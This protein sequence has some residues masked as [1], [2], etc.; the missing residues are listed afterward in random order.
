MKKPK[1]TQQQMTDISVATLLGLERE[2]ELNAKYASPQLQAKLDAIET[3]DACALLVQLG[4]PHVQPQSAQAVRIVKR[5]LKKH[6][7]D[8]WRAAGGPSGAPEPEPAAKTR[9]ARA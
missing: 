5:W 7:S 1:L 3:D 9:K 6:W 4:Q 8:G 2:Q